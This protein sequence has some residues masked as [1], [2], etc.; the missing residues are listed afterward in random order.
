M[1]HVIVKCF[2]HGTMTLTSKLRMRPLLVNP[3]PGIGAS[4][5]VQEIIAH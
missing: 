4:S 1:A 2:I 5:L 3:E